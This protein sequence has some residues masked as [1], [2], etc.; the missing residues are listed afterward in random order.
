[1]PPSGVGCRCAAGESLDPFE[2]AHHSLGA[3]S[4]LQCPMYIMHP[5]AA[6]RPFDPSENPEKTIN[7]HH[8]LLSR[9]LGWK[10]S[11][12]LR[13]PRSVSL[14]DELARIRASWNLGAANP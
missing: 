14:K 6:S 12:V 3:A 10:P 5:S 9:D 4:Y 7:M 1:M 8:E 11:Q 13:T 2:A